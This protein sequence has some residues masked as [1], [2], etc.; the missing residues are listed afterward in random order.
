MLFRSISKAAVKL[1]LIGEVPVDELQGD[2][3]MR[4]S[5]GNLVK[6]G[7][8]CGCWFSGLQRINSSIHTLE[9]GEMGS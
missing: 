2:S 3:E 1:H 9:F 8:I 7:F 4:N 6:T 5:L